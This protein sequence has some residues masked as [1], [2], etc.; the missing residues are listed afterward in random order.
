[1]KEPKEGVAGSPSTYSQ[2]IKSSDSTLRLE[3]GI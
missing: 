3:T 2:L 1:M